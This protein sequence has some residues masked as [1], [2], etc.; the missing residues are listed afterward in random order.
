M[1]SSKWFA[2]LCCLSKHG[3]TGERLRSSKRYRKEIAVHRLKLAVSYG[4]W[5]SP[6]A[7]LLIES[8]SPEEVLVGPAFEWFSQQTVGVGLLPWDSIVWSIGSCSCYVAVGTTV[9]WVNP[10]CLRAPTRANNM[11]ATRDWVFE[12]PGVLQFC[13]CAVHVSELHWQPLNCLDKNK[14]LPICLQYKFSF[15]GFCLNKVLV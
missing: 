7:T 4:R 8:G 11:V 13:S 1:C 5:V 14:C 3:S 10:L 2:A 15:M 9:T 6:L 12:T